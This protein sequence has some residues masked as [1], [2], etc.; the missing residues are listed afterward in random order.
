MSFD[1]VCLAD[2]VE[3]YGLVLLLAII[4]AGGLD[5]LRLEF[6]VFGGAFEG[7]AYGAD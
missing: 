5:C 1:Q 4:I 3:N 2:G 6:C 7:S